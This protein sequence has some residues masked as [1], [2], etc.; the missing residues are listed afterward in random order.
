MK[1][2]Q[3]PRVVLCYLFKKRKHRAM[4][5]ARRE[6]FCPQEGKALS[7]GVELLP[8]VVVK[9]QGKVMER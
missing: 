8:G 1:G 4:P 9:C 6:A 5:G 3:P 2:D 7:A